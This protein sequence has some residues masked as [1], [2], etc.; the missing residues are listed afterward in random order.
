MDEL[1]SLDTPTMELLNAIE[2]N[3][4]ETTPSDAW[5][6]PDPVPVA[7]LLNSDVWISNLDVSNTMGLNYN[8]YICIRLRILRLGPVQRRTTAPWS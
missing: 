6:V 5:M 8:L 7:L 2:A 1:G 3:I 4:L